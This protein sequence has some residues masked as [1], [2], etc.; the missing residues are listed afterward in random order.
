[1]VLPVQTC[2]SESAATWQKTWR[3]PRLN[4]SARIRARLEG[5]L[6]DS[7]RYRF[8]SVLPL[9]VDGFLSKRFLRMDP[10]RTRTGKVKSLQ[11]NTDERRLESD[12]RATKG[13][14]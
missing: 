4:R 6:N 9:H 12:S 8:D 1:M 7:S 13:A 5:T 3:T 10:S 11:M 14:R 2:G